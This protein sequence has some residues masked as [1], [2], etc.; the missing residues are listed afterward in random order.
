MG[1]RK[2]AASKRR[3]CG[4]RH[5]RGPRGGVGRRQA[6]TGS[7]REARQN[8]PTTTLFSTPL[9]P[10]FQSAAL[11]RGGHAGERGRQQS[12]AHSWGRQ[13]GSWGWGGPAA[14]SLLA[15]GPTVGTLLSLPSLH[16]HPLLTTRSLSMHSTALQQ[17]HMW[18]CRRRAVPQ[19]A[20]NKEPACELTENNSRALLTM[21][22]LV[23]RVAVEASPHVIPHA[24]RR[25]LAQREG[26][27]V[28]RTVCVCGW[29]EACS[30]GAGA[31]AR[32][33][34]EPGRSG[35]STAC[36]MP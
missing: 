21:E 32:G 27:H 33:W 16:V 29:G 9:S 12:S 19:R 22:V 4:G 31:G 13:G 28:Q 36:R 15:A 18:A 5:A 23:H 8:W 10:F 14:Q 6:L 35:R 25:H 34:C 20:A 17:A 30:G 2:A 11:G 1:C 26:H 7:A 24:A 3:G